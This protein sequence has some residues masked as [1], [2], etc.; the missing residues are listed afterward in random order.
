MSQEEFNIDFT[1]IEY[2]SQNEAQIFNN[3]LRALIKSGNIAMSQLQ[4]GLANS[5]WESIYDVCHRQKSSYKYLNLSEVIFKLEQIE[6]N[7]REGKYDDLPL[8]V[9]STITHIKTI[10]ATLHKKLE[11]N[12]L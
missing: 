7:I 2:L 11:G 3:L 12:A 6:M 5:D 4:D 10:N 9:L 8:M 1:N